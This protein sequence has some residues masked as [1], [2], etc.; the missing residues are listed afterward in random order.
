MIR[1]NEFYEAEIEGIT[2]EGS[3]IAR[4]E[5]FAVFIPLTVPG[6]RVRFKAVKVLK[7]Y[8]FGI[9]DK[10]IRPSSDRLPEQEQG[11]GCFRQ[12]GGCA[13]RHISYQAEARI[14]EQSVR[15][16]FQRL[17]GFSLDPL[18]ILSAPHTDHY[19][20]K[21]QYPLGLDRNG[22]IIAG[23]YAR[24]SHRI[25]PAENCPLQPVVFSKIVRFVVNFL[26]RNHLS[27][28]QEETHR[29]HYRHIYLRQAPGTGE[30]M[31]C[32]VAA[33][34]NPP[35]IRELA[36]AAQQAFPEIVSVWL[37]VNP[38]QT[39]V[40]LGKEYRLLAG[41]EQITDEFLGK[42]LAISPASFYQVNRG[43]A[44]RL[45]TLAFDFAEFSGTEHLLDLYCGIG[46]IGLSASDRIAR[47]TGVE[48]VPQ[49]VEN[50]RHN[51]EA[52]GVSAEFFC[53]DASGAAKK[54][55]ADGA[56]PDIILVDPPRKG[57]GTEVLEAIFAMAPK[58]VVMI[59]CNPSTAAR[60]CKILASG[61][62]RLLKYQPVDL[63][64]RT[65]HCEC[66]ALLEKVQ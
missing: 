11:C 3:G 25:V 42:I 20:N 50:A 57:C 8:G 53:A 35:K 24:N 40:I 60:D 37:N 41:K 17:G 39:N 45:Y 22:N 62:Y 66:V 51:A 29:G 27:V 56:K 32:M 14:K 63:F 26:S 38:D 21:A 23:F 33:V 49:A 59:S 36:A 43:Q 7:H 55:A 30:I 34:K 18:P 31:L 19:R 9:L 61:G 44:Q 48:I 13:F 46:S 1:K 10:V 47:L 15:D 4:I 5:G 28:Y 2:L 58:K 52:N 65:G 64:P 6:D 12:C 54:L 16:A